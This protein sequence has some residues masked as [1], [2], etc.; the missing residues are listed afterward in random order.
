MTKRSPTKER[1]PRATRSGPE[2]IILG[3]SAS[4]LA[5]VVGALVVLAFRTAEPARPAADPPGPARQV[6]EQFLVPIGI[7]NHGD[8]GAAEVQVVAEL[9]IDGATSSGDQV[10]DFLGGG[11]RQE[12]TFVF[13]ADPAEGELVIS[14][15]GYADP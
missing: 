8:L 7:V 15:T 12:L 5:V 10:V 4:I 14:V 13:A 1:V 2:W 6:G 3:A 11:E 9:T